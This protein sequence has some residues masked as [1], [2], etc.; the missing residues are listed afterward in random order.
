MISRF[1]IAMTLLPTM[2]MQW[3]CA[4]KAHDHDMAMP[5]YAVRIHRRRLWM[6]RVKIIEVPRHVNGSRMALPLW[7]CHESGDGTRRVS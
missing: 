1:G 6:V 7:Q 5:R 3:R 4:I 2:A